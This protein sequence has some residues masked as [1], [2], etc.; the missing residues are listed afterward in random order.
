MST[1]THNPQPYLTLEQ[2]VAQNAAKPQARANFGNRNARKRTVICWGKVCYG[3]RGVHARTSNP[4]GVC[5]DC[6]PTGGW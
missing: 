5:D 6:A 4:D 3:M 2:L 1:Y